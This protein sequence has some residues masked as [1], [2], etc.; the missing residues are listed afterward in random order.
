MVM[1]GIRTVGP[2]GRHTHIA[3]PKI[4]HAFRRDCRA[5]LQID[6]I[7]RSAGRRRR[8]P[9]LLLRQGA[10]AQPEKQ[11]GHPADRTA[12]N[13]SHK[14]HRKP[15]KSRAIYEAMAEGVASVAKRP[16]AV[17]LVA[18]HF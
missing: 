10:R 9:A 16:R 14:A 6:K 7:N 2:S 12:D 15:P 17:V 4:H 8:W 13:P 3:Q 11:T 1:P 5:I 18:L